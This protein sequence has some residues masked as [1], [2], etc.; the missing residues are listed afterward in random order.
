MKKKIMALGLAILACLSMFGCSD[1]GKRIDQM[2]MDKYLVLGQYTGFEITNSMAPVSDTK[3]ENEIKE[4]YLTKGVKIGLKEGTAKLG[5]ICN[6]D[7]VG[8]VDDVAFEGGSAKNQRITL[9]EGKYIPGFEDGIDGMNVG[10]TK[11]VEVTFP[12]DY[13]EELAGKKAIFKIT[14]NYIFPE[15]TDAVVAQFEDENYS[16]LEEMRSYIRAQLEEEYEENSKKDIG[17]QALALAIENC[18]FKE[19]PEYLIEAQ[20]E[21]IYKN[22][23]PVEAQ[24][25]VSVDEYVA[26]IYQSTVTELATRYVKQRM[27]AKAIADKENI[28]VSEEEVKTELEALAAEQGLTLEG[29]LTLNGMTEE[30]YREYMLTLKVC[31]FL[32]ENCTRID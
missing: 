7:F 29:Y 23:S 32:Y 19:I 25:N 14:L 20:K 10:E 12:D 22:Y 1:E 5:D 24:Y 13:T 27:V 17:S 15:L 18:E 3:V 2:N 8:Y 21:E 26:T 9:G 30:Y 4:I 31:D 11:D 16:T 28:S 6:I